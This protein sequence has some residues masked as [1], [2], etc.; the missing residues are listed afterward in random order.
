M[1]LIFTDNQTLCLTSNKKE[2]DNDLSF[3][4]SFDFKVHMT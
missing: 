3:S 2:I 4:L 1:N